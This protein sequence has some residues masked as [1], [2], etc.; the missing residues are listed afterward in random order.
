M[1][2]K[3]LIC[4]KILIYPTF[5]KRR[6]TQSAPYVLPTRLACGKG[7]Q[8]GVGWGLTRGMAYLRHGGAVSH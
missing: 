4:Y 7:S 3:F 1:S 6:A 8:V 2:I 5:V